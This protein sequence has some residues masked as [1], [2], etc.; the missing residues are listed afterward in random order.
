MSND[1]DTDG[2]LPLVRIVN[3]QL[4]PAPGVYEID[5][6]HTF[7]GFSAQHLVVGRVRGRFESVRGTITIADNPADSSVAVTIDPASINTL[8]PMRDN[9]LRSAQHLDTGH[10]ATITYTQQRDRR[11]PRREMAR[12]RQPRTA[13]THPAADPRGSLRRRRR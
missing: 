8:M 7:V 11:R 13:R 3:H 4:V 6:V 5:P 9:D 2:P 12:A 10:H 1:A